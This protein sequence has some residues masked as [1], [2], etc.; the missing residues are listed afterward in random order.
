MGGLLSIFYIFYTSMTHHAAL[1]SQLVNLIKGYHGK[2][3]GLIIY[4]FFHFSGV[5]NYMFDTPVPSSFPSFPPLG[6]GVAC[7]GLH[8]ITRVKCMHG[9]IN[10]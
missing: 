2:I 1:I 7:L 10:W 6:G 3:P 8:L 5:C 4:S 9:T